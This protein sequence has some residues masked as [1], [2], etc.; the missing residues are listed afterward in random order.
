MITED[1]VA[2]QDKLNITMLIINIIVDI[3]KDILILEFI[4]NNEIKSI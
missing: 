2:N 3:W 4:S 1:N